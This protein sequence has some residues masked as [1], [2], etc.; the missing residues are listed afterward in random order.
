MK[1]IFGLILVAV[2]SLGGVILFKLGQSGGGDSGASQPSR[3]N[4]SMVDGKQIVT[5]R[6]KGGYT[7]K[8]SIV[9]AGV[10]TILR[11]DTIGTFDCSS[12]LRIPSLNVAENLPATGSTDIALGTL[13]AGTISGNCGMG[14]YPF[15]IIVEN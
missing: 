5:L 1:I 12:V 3:D 2:L 6:A 14:M 7:P 10:P 4:V 11:V 9:K 15:Q 13:S 8:V